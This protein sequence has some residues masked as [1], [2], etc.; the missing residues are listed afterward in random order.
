VPLL[1]GSCVL[2]SVVSSRC[3]CLW[4]PRVCQ[5]DVVLLMPSDFGSM[6]LCDLH[7]LG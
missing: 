2:V 7:S 4:R 6:S 5:V 3:P 1:E